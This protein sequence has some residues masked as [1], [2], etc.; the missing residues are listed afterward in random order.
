AARVRWRVRR[1]PAKRAPARGGGSRAYRRD[2]RL[3]GE[4]L[5]ARAVARAVVRLAVGVRAAARA[6]HRRGRATIGALRADGAGH[7]PAVRERARARAVGRISGVVLPVRARRAPAEMVLDA[8]SAAARG[9]VR[10]EPDLLLAEA[11]EGR[12]RLLARRA[13]EAGGALRGI[14]RRRPS[15]RR[16]AAGRARRIAA[17]QQGKAKKGD[18]HAPS[19]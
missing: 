1:F 3:A 8:R 4:P 13:R 2:E 7:G 14:W 16:A 11:V 15:G 12:E 19:I 9:H 6:V 5:R 17:A 18:A 10:V